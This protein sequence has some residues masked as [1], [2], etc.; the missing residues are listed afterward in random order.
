MAAV[1]ASHPGEA[2]MEDAAIEV[3]VNDPFDIR[4]QKTILF[5]KTVVV[6]LFK[7]LEMIFNTLIIL[8]FLWLA[9]AIF[10][11]CYDDGIATRRRGVSFEDRCIEE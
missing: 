6:D 10:P 2:I 1:F 7:S 4:T 5:G 11:Y 3:T 8:R 9:R